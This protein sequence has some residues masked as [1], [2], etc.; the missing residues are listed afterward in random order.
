MSEVPTFI[1]ADPMNEF[2]VVTTE[3]PLVTL[4]GIE[5]GKLLVRT[6][7]ENPEKPSRTLGVA[8]DSRMP[9]A[10]D[11]EVRYSYLVRFSKQP[12]VDAEPAGRHWHEEKNEL[13]S[14]AQGNFLVV[15]EDRETKQQV[16][17]TLHSDARGDA[18]EA[19][20]ETVVVPVGVAHAVLPLDDG[21]STLLVMADAPGTI[22]DEF[23]YEMSV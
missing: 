23:P 7:R 21:D 3:I 16:T 18:G 15:L 20:E 12:G 1:D 22:E 13:M 14:A 19:L 5:L 10:E 9:M 2:S 17:C 8:W 6:R 11:F 4:N